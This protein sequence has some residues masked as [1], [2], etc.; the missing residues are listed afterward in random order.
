MG[1]AVAAVPALAD[2]AGSW[3]LERRI[4]DALAGETWAFDGRARFAPLTDGLDYLETGTLSGPDGRSMRAERRYLWRAGT[5]GLDVYCAG[6]GFFHH[7]PAGETRPEAAHPCGADL[8]QVRYDFG[9]WPR[10][11]AVWQVRGPR[12]EYVLHST[13]AR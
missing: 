3:R 8:Y 2:F 7:I 10:W 13:Y 6:G 5:A 4:E 9:D 12:K 11:Q 1:N